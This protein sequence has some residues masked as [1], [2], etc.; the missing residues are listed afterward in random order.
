[1][2]SRNIG[3]VEVSVNF[4]Q[5]SANLKSMPE[6]SQKHL[7]NDSHNLRDVVVLLGILAAMIILAVRPFG[8]RVFEIG[9]AQHNIFS[10]ILV[11]GIV[12]IILV[13]LQR[14]G[15]IFADNP[16]FSTDH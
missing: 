1:M 4:Y 13:I 8:Y 2:M 11:V 6:K 5:S 16:Q 15:I 10:V 9:L 3:I 12:G 14:L 7:P